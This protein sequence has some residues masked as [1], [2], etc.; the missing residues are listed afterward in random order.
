MTWRYNN[1][2]CGWAPLPPAA[3]Y[4]P[5]YGFYYYGSSVSIGFGWGLGYSSWCFVGYNHFQHHGLHAYRVP[6]H[7]A[8]PIYD[9]TTPVNRIVGQNNLVVNRGVPPENVTAATRQEVRRVPIRDAG[10]AGAGPKERLTASGRT[11]EVYRPTAQVQPDDPGIVQRS[12]REMPRTGGG[13]LSAPS[14]PSALS[15]PSAER[16]QMAES[17]PSAQRAGMTRPT[18][19]ASATGTRG[20]TLPE[21]TAPVTQSQP[22]RHCWRSVRPHGATVQARG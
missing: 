11:L 17:A 4:Y 15:A 6:D 8:R 22:A 5:G 2:Y 21:A 19:N 13:A 18:P 16:A 10:S 20:S 9:S 12:R 7:H 14:A 1:A 3:C